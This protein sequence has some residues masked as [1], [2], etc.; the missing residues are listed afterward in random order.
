M[1]CDKLLHNLIHLIF[2]I[3]ILCIPVQYNKYKIMN[4]ILPG[5][6]YNIVMSSAVLADV[7]IM[8]LVR[9][10]LTITPAFIL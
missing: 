8:S 10:A 5:C 9:I 7:E 3:V 2:L 4:N 1:L 6:G